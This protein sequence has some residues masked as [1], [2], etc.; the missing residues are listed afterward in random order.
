MITILINL[1][2]FKYIKNM[3][4]DTKKFVE[5]AFEEVQGGE[6][7]E[8]GFYHTPNGSKIKN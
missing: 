8:Y 6:Y 1:K 2:I 3:S 4:T 5:R 7:D